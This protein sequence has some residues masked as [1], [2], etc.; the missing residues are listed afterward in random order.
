MSNIIIGY[1]IEII[2]TLWALGAL[3]MNALINAAKEARQEFDNP[4]F[5]A[6]VVV[7]AIWPIVAIFG[8]ISKALK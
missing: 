3:T 7:C 6:K 2:L 8:A 5:V 1:E 4:S